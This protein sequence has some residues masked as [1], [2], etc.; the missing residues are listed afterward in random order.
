LP[1]RFEHFIPN[2]NTF[3]AGIHRGSNEKPV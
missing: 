2:P 1:L 3:G